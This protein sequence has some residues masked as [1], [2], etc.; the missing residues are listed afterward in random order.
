MNADLHPL[1]IL[2]VEDNPDDAELIFYALKKFNLARSVVHLQD[3]EAA[4]T[5]LRDPARPL[6]QVVFLDV[7]L[8][9]I[10]GLDVLAA[11]RQQKRT[12]RLPVVMLTSSAVEDDILTSYQRGANSYVVKPIDFDEFVA[13][14]RN[15]AFYWLLIN[16]Y[17][18]PSSI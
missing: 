11:L 2:L 18:P 17:M 10:N 1:D 13:T 12:A 9:C 8:P 3:G 5:Y 15:T 6:P 7:Q 16:R 14:I 4:L